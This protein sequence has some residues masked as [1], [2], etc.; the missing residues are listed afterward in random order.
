MD[1]AVT[2]SWAVVET[3]FSIKVYYSTNNLTNVILRTQSD[4]LCESFFTFQTQWNESL[5]CHMVNSNSFS[6][7][8]TQRTESPLS[9]EEI[10]L[11]LF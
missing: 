8:Q 10:K 9:E 11:V 6:M 2:Y 3:E 1:G 7:S 4:V 5:I